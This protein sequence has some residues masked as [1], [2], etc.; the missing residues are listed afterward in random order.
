MSNATAD[1]N[2]YVGPKPFERGQPLFGRDREKRELRYLLTSERIVLLYSPS[3][4]G[5]SSLVNAGLLPDVEKRFDISGPI[6]VNRQPPAGVSNRYVWS[7]I[8]D[9]EKT[10]KVDE[11]N[12][13]EYFLERKKERNQLLVFDQFEEVLRVDPSDYAVKR[14]FF[15]Q[16]G[17]LVSDPSIWALFVIREDY[18]A[19]LDPFARL[20]P[21][22]LQNRFRIDRLAR[23]EAE[24]A[25]ELPT[26][27]LNRKY[28]PGVVAKLVS[29]LAK[30][31]IQDLTGKLVEVVGEYVEPVQ[32]Q[33]VC[34]DLWN[35]MEADDLSIDQAD[36]GDVGHALRRYYAREVLEA[37]KQNVNCERIIREWFEEQLITGDGV[38]NQVRMEE[39]QSGGLANDLVLKMTEAHLVRRDERGGITWF[40][41]AHDRLVGPIR[42]SNQEW[43]GSHLLMLQQRASRW[44]RAEEAEGLLLSGAELEQGLQEA[45]ELRKTN[46]LSPAEEQFL[47]ES[48]KAELSRKADEALVK[49]RLDVAEERRQTAERN[50]KTAEERRLRDKRVNRVLLSFA[51]AMVILL[52][53]AAW[54]Y[55]LAK[56]AEEKAERQSKVAGTAVAKYDLA[57]ISM[58][59]REGKSAEALAYLGRALQ[60]VPGSKELGGLAGP[61][62][63][64]FLN[65]GVWRIPSQ[66][67]RQEAAITEL[68]MSTSGGR[69]VTA[70]QAGQ[71]RGWDA[72][73]GQGIGQPFA[74]SGAIRLNDD[75]SWAVVLKGNRQSVIQ[76]DTGKELGGEVQRGNVAF[77]E[78]PGGQ[79]DSK[80]RLFNATSTEGKVW[81]IDSQKVVGTT[82]FD[83]AKSFN[84][85]A[86]RTD[87]LFIL[88]QVALRWPFAN[89]GANLGKASFGTTIETAVLGPR[90]ER[91]A[92]I[93]NKGSKVLVSNFNG[94]IATELREL[95]S[96]EQV[97]FSQDGKYVVVNWTTQNPSATGIGLWEA[98]TGKRGSQWSSSEGATFVF[99]SELPVF[100]EAARE[101]LIVRSVLT[102]EQVAQVI[103]QGPVAKWV[104][105]RNGQRLATVAKDGKQV[106]IWDVSASKGKKA[107]ALSGNLKELTKEDAAALAEMAKALGGMRVEG[108]E[109]PV[110]VSLDDR[111]KICEE[112]RGAQGLSPGVQAIVD[113]FLANVP[114]KK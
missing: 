14:E 21:T 99:E 4:A 39:K 52:C 17:E 9:L 51:A 87:V 84:L 30:V 59:D 92:A 46:T 16:L 29:N 18:L 55:V 58:L 36:V 86:D 74:G 26:A 20:L 110:P 56:K 85:N 94:G 61:L 103:T 57:T 105:A 75:G 91:V 71:A 28:A 25:I 11:R 69:I 49:E 1:P 89:P 41:L 102:G 65:G 106:E 10:D 109:D 50:L 96:A 8:A 43:F 100:V 82:F 104:L 37:S 107:A 15:E 24:K 42:R 98:A 63:E 6:R 76:V 40:E 3:G 62:V 95:E 35:E 54:Q 22:H 19:P 44:R 66:Q 64:K 31:T 88:N 67:I 7:C 68:V 80:R 111:L 45:V 5:K 79:K 23:A 72:S 114:G 13:A 108:S 34:Y 93:V 70:N 112:L 32:L 81:D 73:T 83:P 60:A 101:T 113:S 33:V 48:S 97:G 27:K 12:L 38:R 90:G 77:A 2:P 47:K 53:L 78:F